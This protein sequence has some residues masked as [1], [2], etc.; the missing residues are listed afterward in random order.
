MYE[1]YY[2]MSSIHYTSQFESQGVEEDILVWQ[3]WKS[4][5]ARLHSVLNMRVHHRR[6]ITVALATIATTLLAAPCQTAAQQLGD[7]ALWL[8]VSGTFR[9]RYASLT[10]QFYQEAPG[11][12]QALSLRTTLLAELR[13]NLVTAGLELADS[14]VYLAD[15]DTPLGNTHVN[16]A[17]LLQAYVT[18]TI[19]DAI[20]TG[21]SLRV[22]LGR[23]TMDVGSRRL[24][25]RNKFRNTINAFTGLHLDW[26][27]PS[28]DV[29]RV[30]ATVPV[31]RRAGSFE[32]NETRADI[33]RP[34]AIFW[35]IFFGP[36]PWHHS[37]RGE[38]QVFGLHERDSDRYRTK[39]R[40]II[41]PGFRLYRPPARG[42]FDFELEA[43]LQLGISRATAYVDDSDDDPHRA[44]FLH[45]SAGRTFG[46]A[47]RPR[48][49]AQYDYASGD[50]D[51][52][53][54]PFGRFDTLYGARRFEFG[55]T[56]IYGAFAR[57]NINSPGVRIEVAPASGTD[58]FLGYRAF[59]LARARDM[60]TTTG[61]RD[62]DGLSGKFLGHQVEG[63][64]RWGG[65]SHHATLE[66]G[67][68][69]LWVGKFP[70]IA[71]TGNPDMQNPRYLYTQVILRF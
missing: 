23:Q 32:E 65:I 39:N 7:G 18:A 8:N 28:W 55:P 35:G 9:A 47:W 45:G 21:S 40:R 41:T 63:R 67:F 57:S 60:W 61:V 48:I 64:V 27:G 1:I 46:G 24:V 14:R 30:F 34:E 10:N 43:A 66:A 13:Y 6:G 42:R 20:S 37:I 26:I 59:W 44:Y 33:E 71:P 50:G 49:V 38:F 22:R 5:P 17:D 54:H 12:D 52:A 36:R 62:W 69:H 70:K 68:A 2:I 25:A 4:I 29:V 56:G 53:Y 11:D 58:G 3:S 51:V 31:E 15:D 19:P 16:P